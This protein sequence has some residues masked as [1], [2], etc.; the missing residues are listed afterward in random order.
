MIRTAGTR[1]SAFVAVFVTTILLAACSGPTT[2]TGAAPASDDP[3]GWTAYA[4]CM[5]DNGL[6]DFPDPDRE[7]HIPI[8]DDSLDMD[9]DV[10]KKANETCEPL[11]PKESEAE[12]QEDYN[13]DLEFA[14]CMRKEGIPGFPDPP[15]PGSEPATQGDTND[16]TGFEL[17][18]EQFKAVVETCGE[19][20]PE[21]E[22]GPLP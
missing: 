1:A 3:P 9:S 10:A 5:R 19:L 22:E 14:K 15:A 8:E 2:P 11:M 4:Q 7:G 6:P 20:L 16:G 21:G 12:Q 17:G 13:A 18:S